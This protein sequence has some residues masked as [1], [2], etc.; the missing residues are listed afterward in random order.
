MSGRGIKKALSQTGP[1]RFN[2][3]TSTPPGAG[4]M[5]SRNEAGE[6]SLALAIG[7]I[8]QNQISAPCAAKFKRRKDSDRTWLCQKTT[9]PQLPF[10]R[11]CSVVHK[12][13]PVLA[14]R[15]HNNRVVSI[16]HNLNASEC[17]IYGGCTSAM[18][19]VFDSFANKGLSNC[20]SPI[21]DCCNN[22]STRE[23]RGQPAPGSSWSSDGCPD[24]L[25]TAREIASSL[26][27]QT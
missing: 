19:C 21:P 8:N 14:G 16:P 9:A 15:I 2:T 22:N 7:R 10:F 3:S 27:R 24:E 6:A 18:R 1:R 12:A 11:I 5:P 25:V 23:D 20:N 4:R 26:A 13:S 17:G